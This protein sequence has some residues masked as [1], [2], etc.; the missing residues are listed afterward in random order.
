MPQY[1]TSTAES[2]KNVFEVFTTDNSFGSSKD[3]LSLTAKE[4]IVNAIKKNFFFGTGYHPS[5]F[6]GDGGEQGWEGGDYFFLGSFAQY[7]LIGL[8]FFLPYYV[9]SIR[10]ISKSIKIIKNNRMIIYSNEHIFM[11]PV[12]INIASGAFMIRNLI[13][14]PNWFRPIASTNTSIGTF[15]YFGFLI[16]SYFY[17]QKELFVIKEIKDEN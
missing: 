6:S 9:I 4:G 13:E 2:I 16:G 12:L 14:Y 1:L 17:I 10:V 3:R 7:G 8:L 15:I 5:W 11:Y